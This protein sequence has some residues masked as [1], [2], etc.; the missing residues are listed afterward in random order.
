MAADFFL[1]SRQ[2]SQ[3][4][5]DSLC[6]HLR[7]MR[8]KIHAGNMDCRVVA[9]AALLGTVVLTS[10]PCEVNSASGWK[11]YGNKKYMY[12]PTKM[13]WI[14]ARAVCL[15]K[16]SA[17]L[18]TIDN[19]RLNSWIKVQHARHVYTHALPSVNKYL[20]TLRFP[21]PSQTLSLLV[22]HSTP[23]IKLRRAHLRHNI[24]RLFCLLQLRKWRHAPFHQ[25]M[26]ARK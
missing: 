25:T 23:H 4:V 21:P 11:R 1:R 19:A 17:D 24:I 26:F 8:S 6:T 20:Y 9:A 22:L 18:V 7:T 15:K 2:T 10:L 14:D 3:V 12:I 5:I 13:P 16:G